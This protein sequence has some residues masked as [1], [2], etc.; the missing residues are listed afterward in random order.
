MA[1]ITAEGFDRLSAHA[2]R[3]GF[4]T[5]AYD[6]GVRDEA[7]PL[8]NAHP[9][10]EMG[11]VRCGSILPLALTKSPK[12]QNAGSVQWI[13]AVRQTSDLPHTDCVWDPRL[14]NSPQALI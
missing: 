14:C 8:K 13:G 5:A 12:N 6:K 2:L 4:I 3:V 9:K 7:F 11:T 10:D 1:G